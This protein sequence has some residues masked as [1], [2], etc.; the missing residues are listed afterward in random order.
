[1]ATAYIDLAQDL[2]SPSPLPTPPPR[3]LLVS[4]TQQLC[5]LTSSDSLAQLVSLVLRSPALWPSPETPAFGTGTSVFDAFIQSCLF[6]AG[7]GLH[8]RLA[9]FVRN[10]LGVV[11]RESDRTNALLRL[12]IVSAVLSGLQAVQNA[13]GMLVRKVEDAALGLWQA[14]LPV[15]GERREPR[16]NFPRP[17]GLCG[18]SALDTACY[19]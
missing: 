16:R 1:M 7:D 3:P 11:E 5:T 9:G 18:S 8:L 6:C 4:L 2:L 10:V 17:E 14:V 15:L 19:D 12:A 13:P